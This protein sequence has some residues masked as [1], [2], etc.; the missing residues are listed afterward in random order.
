MN[1]KNFPRRPAF[2]L[3]ELLLVIAVMTLLVALLLPAVQKVRELANQTRCLNNL[4][5]MGLALHGYEN[6]HRCLPPG[7]TSTAGPP[8]PGVEGPAYYGFDTSPGW[9]WGAFLLPHLEQSAL[10]SQINFDEDMSLD[11]YLPVR[12]MPVA[13]YQCPSD[14]GVGVYTVM[15][16]RNRPLVDCFT[17]SYVACMGNNSEVGEQADRG[18]GVFW[19]NSRVR[20]ADITDGATSTIAIGERAALFCR[21]PWAG[22]VNWGSVQ[23]TPGAPVYLAAIEEAPTQVLARAGR[24]T[25]LY[26][27]SMPYD[28]FSGHP[29]RVNFL[30]CD[31]SARPLTTTVTQTTLQALSTRAGN[32]TIDD[33]AY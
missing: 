32:E 33:G 3:I 4:R 20:M 2:T 17:N 16:E 24:L 23:T 22:A 9:G 29:Q 15:T 19:K 7:Y 11:A 10:A 13:I 6:V 12:T 8:P 18:T 27:Y 31:G 26:P 21:T 14:T 5:Q 1:C 25:L 28:F 30:F